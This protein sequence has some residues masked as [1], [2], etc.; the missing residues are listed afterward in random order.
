MKTNKTLL[1]IVPA[2]LVVFA[3]A[4]A[5]LALPRLTAEAKGKDWIGSWDTQVTVVNQNAKFPGLMT[6]TSDGNVFADETP[7]PLETTGHGNWIKTGPNEGAYAFI[8]LVGNT[9]PT[10]WTKYKVSGTLKFNDKTDQWSGPF[11]I[12]V[13]DQDGHVLLSDTGTMH[14][15]RI[16]AGQ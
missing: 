16:V 12:D 7:S 15:T 5:A 8:A 3:V 13:V 1:T 9:N 14:G 6:F 11:K 10:Q 4:L 2:S